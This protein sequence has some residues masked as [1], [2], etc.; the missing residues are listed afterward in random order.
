MK[1]MICVFGMGL[2][3]FLG[4]SATGQQS[5]PTAGLGITRVVISKRQIAYGGTSFGSAGQYEVLAG[6]AYGELDPRAPSNAEI[7]NVNRAPLNARGHAEYSVDFMILKPADA[8]K[9][10]GRLIYDFVNRG[11]NT[12]LSHLNESGDTFAANDAGNGFLMN[13]GYTVAWSGWQA[14]LPAKSPLLRANVP[15]VIE[16]GKPMTGMSREEFTDVPP[17]P[18]FTQTLTYPALL[19]TTGTTL[20]VREREADPRKPLPASSWHFIDERHVEIV[21][22]PGFDRGALYEFIYPATNETVADIGLAASRDFVSFLRYSEQDSTGQP[23][24]AREPGIPF[25]AAFAF[26]VSQTGRAIKD[27]IYQ[28]FNADISGRMVFDGALPLLSGP[29]RTFTNFEFAQPGRFARQHEDHEYGGDQFPFT[30]AT[31]KDPASGKSDGILMQCEKSHTCP[32]IVHLDS[33]TEFWQS[34]DSL[35]VTDTTGHPI[36]LPENVRAYMMSGLAHNV[37]ANWN[38]RGNC[39]QLQNAMNY[40]PYARALLLALDR[41]ITEGAAPPPTTFPSLKNHTLMTLAKVQ[42]S[43]PAIPGSPFSP[44]FDQLQIIDQKSMPP[45]SSGPAYPLFFAAVDADGN[46]QGGIALP[47]IAVPIATFSGRNVRAEGF[48]PGELC[49]LSGSYIPFATTKQERLANG[50]PRLSLE[51]RYKTAQ[52]YA[53][54]RKRA[55]DAL[56]QQGFVLPEDADVLTHS[57]PLPGTTEGKLQATSRA[58]PAKR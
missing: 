15:T 6:T 16:K 57:M 12:A 29:R 48:S 10:N 31:T 3:L 39:Q 19:D 37:A 27:F 52:E 46:P 20:T 13:H 7:V 53:D 47:E 32:R 35:L 34:R 25:K 54:K 22:A 24:P 8:K 33:D 9:G 14:D 2:A 28:G 55:V 40:A 49:G 4:S 11:R 38:T 21:A 51:E 36:A 30:Y 50:D 56:V 26:G 1:K 18:V 41:W 17:G 43:Y 42:A 44:L 45:E 5:A 23:N 58:I